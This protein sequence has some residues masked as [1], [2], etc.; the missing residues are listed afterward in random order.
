MALC[1][2][3][4]ARA[5]LNFWIEAGT[6]ALLLP[7]KISTNKPN[8]WVFCFIRKEHFKSRTL[9]LLD[10]KHVLSLPVVTPATAPRLSF[11]G[12]TFIFLFYIKFTSCHLSGLLKLV[13]FP[14]GNYIYTVKTPILLPYYFI[15]IFKFYALFFFWMK[16]WETIIKTTRFPSY[17]H[18][19][20][21]SYKQAPCKRCIKWFVSGK[22]RQL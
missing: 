1:Q 3:S 13:G 12:I 18:N 2:G 22:R 14:R 17:C 16:D 6:S 20:R 19:R 21:I 5:G 15:I 11:A 4:A 8:Q 7:L 9:L 10:T